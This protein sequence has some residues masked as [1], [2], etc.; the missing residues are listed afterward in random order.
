M[1]VSCE[2]EFDTNVYLFCCI[3]VCELVSMPNVGYVTCGC[4]RHTF[5]LR[6]IAPALLG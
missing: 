3:C 2:P 5:V 1:N 4:Q 6:R